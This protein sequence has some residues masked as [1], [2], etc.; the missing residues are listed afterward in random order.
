MVLSPRKYPGVEGK[1]WSFSALQGARPSSTLYCVLWKFCTYDDHYE[2]CHDWP[3]EWCSRVADYIEKLSL[4]RERKERKTKSSSFSSSSLFWLLPLDA[5]SPGAAAISCGFWSGDDV[6]LFISSACGDVCSSMSGCHHC[7]IC[8]AAFC[9]ALQAVLQ[10]APCDG[11]QG[12]GAHDV[13]TC[14][15]WRPLGYS[16]RKRAWSTSTCWRWSQ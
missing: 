6:C 12:A 16:P 10:K 2:E 8:A 1:V 14:W 5:G 13:H 9:D 11:P 3:D 15:I 7:S 4:Q